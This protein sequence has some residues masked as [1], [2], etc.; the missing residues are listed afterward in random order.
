MSTD[1]DLIKQGLCVD[2]GPWSDEEI[3]AAEQNLGMDAGEFVD[4]CDDCFVSNVAGGSIS[5]AKEWLRR[6]PVLARPTDTTIIKTYGAGPTEVRTIDFD[7]VPAEIRN[8][9]LRNVFGI[10]G[11]YGMGQLEAEDPEIAGMMDYF[12]KAVEAMER[13]GD[14]T[15]EPH[16][17]VADALGITE[18]LH[19]G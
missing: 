14:L 4:C 9:V 11:A 7:K 15:L 6:P 2:C 18:P 16:R 13:S 10:A 5:R 1:R 8:N 17:P 12:C 3:V 19:P